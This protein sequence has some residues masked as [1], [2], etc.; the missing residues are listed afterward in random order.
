MTAAKKLSSQKLIQN[1][2]TTLKTKQEG[3]PMVP[4]WGLK[5]KFKV[6][7]ESDKLPLL[8]GLF[9]HAGQFCKWPGVTQACLQARSMFQE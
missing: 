7:G 2:L 3:N 6:E 5:T 4:I 8:C 1:Y 9:G